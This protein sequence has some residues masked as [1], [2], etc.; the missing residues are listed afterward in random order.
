M[1]A[2]ITGEEPQ[3]GATS[4]AV[5][6]PQFSQ[7]A[8]AV[9]PTALSPTALPHVGSWSVQLSSDQSIVLTL[10]ADGTFRWM[11]TKGG[12]SSEFNGDYRLDGERLTLVRSLDLQQMAGDWT[13]GESGFTFKLDGATNSGLA[14]SRSS[15]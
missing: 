14:F 5:E 10:D 11:A 7:P 6:M 2:S 12:S 13:P 9:P 8:A 1:L 4:A 3:V 15:T